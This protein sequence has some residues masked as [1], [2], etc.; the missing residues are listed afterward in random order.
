[1]ISDREVEFLKKRLRDGFFGFSKDEISS[2][3]SATRRAGA[4]VLDHR[5]LSFRREDIVHPEE[6]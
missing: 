1:M 3:G 6:R 4:T 5:S 2:V